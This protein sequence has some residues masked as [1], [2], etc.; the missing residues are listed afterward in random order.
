MI[1]AAIGV[2]AA[3]MTPAPG[4]PHVVAGQVRAHS[5]SDVTKLAA[6][7]L[8]RLAMMTIAVPVEESSPG[9]AA[10][11]VSH[12]A[13]GVLLFGTAAPRNLASALAT[14]RR[15][16]P[17]HLGLLVMTDEE[18]GAVQRM[19]NLVGSLPWPQTMGTDWSPSHIE[20]AVAAIARR[21]AA[22]GVNMDLAPV[23]DV[24]G[25]HVAPGDSD[26]DG[27]RSF[28]GNRSLVLRDALAYADGL[29][30]GHV[31]PVFK[32]FPGLGGASGNTDVEPARTLPWKR[33]QKVAIPPYVAG[34]RAG[35]PAI[36]V[37]NATVPG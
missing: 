24:D 28:G 8:D 37:S 5:C 12:G 2:A 23:V 30:A 26:P 35:V 9:E 31:I 33:L 29:E 16:V 34:I 10:S 13:G 1:V 15:D 36:M 19:A 3:A 22:A 21:M 4:V 27:Y 32:H 14:L 25:R 20:R 11:E 6:W 18:G 17:Q 7:P